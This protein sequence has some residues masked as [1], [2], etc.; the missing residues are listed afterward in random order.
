M[1]KED[2]GAGKLVIPEV[3]VPR[4]VLR[5][6]EFLVENEAV[7]VEDLFLGEGIP[8]LVVRIREDLDT[9][10]PHSFI[11][12]LTPAPEAMPHISRATLSDTMTR[13][14]KRRHFKQGPTRASTFPP[15]GYYPLFRQ[16]QT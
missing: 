11:I 12:S 7:M 1:I 3:K 4:E 13:L 8:D 15:S 10:S 14:R 16:I 5:M 2:D 6:L 9:V